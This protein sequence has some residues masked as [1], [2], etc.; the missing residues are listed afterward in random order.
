[1]DS[2]SSV[3]SVTRAAWA[4]ASRGTEF[5]L[6]GAT[7]L[8]ASKLTFGFGAKSGGFAFPGAL[9]FLTERSTIGFGSST[10]SSANGGTANS[11]ASRAVFHFTHFL[12]ATDRADGFFAVNFT[13]GTFRGFAVHLAFGASADGV[14]FSGA[15]GIVAQPFALRVAS[16]CRSKGHDGNSKNKILHISQ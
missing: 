10:G 12:G 15:D 6:F 2:K 5:F 16:R 11:L 9:G 8:F 14:A 7:G 4:V 13:F 1:L 3:T